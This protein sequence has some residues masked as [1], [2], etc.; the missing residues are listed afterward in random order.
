MR[1]KGDIYEL[2]IEFGLSH[3]TIS[4]EIW[5]GVGVLLDV[6]RN[7]RYAK[8]EWPSPVRMQEYHRIYSRIGKEKVKAFT[9]DLE[10][11]DAG[12]FGV[13]D[14][15]KYAVTSS[16][17]PLKQNAYYNGAY[18]SCC[19]NVF[20]TAPTGQII[21]YNVN[22]PGSWHDMTVSREL[23]PALSEAAKQRMYI[24]ADQGF[25]GRCYD[26]ICAEKPNWSHHAGA[27]THIRQSAE[28]SN[29]SLNY[30]ARLTLPLPS[31]NDANRT[32]I[33]ELAVFLTN[34]RC[35]FDGVNQIR[36]TYNAEYDN[37]QFSDK[38]SDVD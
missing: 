9:A 23:L 27:I 19:N 4:R 22:A 6:L 26:F 7:D 29:R 36:T 34:F 24:I 13:I 32:S 17:D 35:A 2:Q 33:I 21:W 30:W 16:T 8:V 14:G 25:R 38:E 18:G 3:S 11:K 20:V 37:A 1:S 5:N 28:W 15:T 12:V 10:R 31:D